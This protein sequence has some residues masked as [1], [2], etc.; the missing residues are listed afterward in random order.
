MTGKGI[1]TVRVDD[2]TKEKATELFEELGLSLSAAIN[3][4][5]KRA[6][7]DGGLPFDLVKKEDKRKRIKPLHSGRQKGRPAKIK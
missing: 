7:R 4:F 5:L 6:I 2:E 1:I 3:I